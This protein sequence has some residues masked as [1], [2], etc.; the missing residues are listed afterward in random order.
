[1]D[2]HGS[3][4]KGELDELSTTSSRSADLG[5]TWVHMHREN[6]AAQEW[7]RKCDLDSFVIEALSAEETRPRCTV[8]GNSAILILRG[9]NGIANLFWSASIVPR[10]GGFQAFI[11]AV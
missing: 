10:L 9:V 5:F 8:H 3:A 11:S 6:S 7:L 2:G 1:M 4:R